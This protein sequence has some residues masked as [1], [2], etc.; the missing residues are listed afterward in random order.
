MGKMHQSEFQY[1]EVA[2]D[3]SLWD[4]DIF[5]VPQ[6]V[7]FRGQKLYCLDRWWAGLS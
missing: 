2:F 3:F 7:G 6:A 1:A 5:F 4:W